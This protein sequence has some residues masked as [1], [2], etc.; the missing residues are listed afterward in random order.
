MVLPIIAIVGRPNVGKSALYNRL[1]GQR[2]AIVSDV[3]GTTRDRVSSDAHWLDS[4][5]ILVD[6]G[7]IEAEDEMNPESVSGLGATQE[8]LGSVQMQTSTALEDADVLIFVVDAIA[9]VTAKDH[10]AADAV[11]RAGKPVVLAAN[12][13]DNDARELTVSEF[14]E[15]GAGD[16]IPISAYHDIGIGELMDAVL[17]LAGSVSEPETDEDTLRIAIV[18]RPN[19]G[20]STLLNAITGESRAIVS[21]VAGT[22]RDAIDTSYTYSGRAITL[23]DTAGLRRRGKAGRGIEKFSVLRAI[24]AIERADVALLLLDA[25]ELITAQDTHVAGLIEDAV[26]GAVIV[27]NKWDLADHDEIDQQSANRDIRIRLK[28][29]E[30]APIT[31]TSAVHGRGVEGMLDAALRVYAEWTRTVDGGDLQRVLLAALAEHPIP[32]HGRGD[33]H[34]TRVVQTRTAPPSF[35]FR[36]NQPD[37]IHFS[38]KRYLENKIR[39]EFGFAGAPLRLHFRTRI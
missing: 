24:Q 15:L 14:Y 30:G 22:T 29:L 39:D 1:L 18:G 20:K 19:V 34:M 28:F 38:Y 3:A 25:T 5:F 9:G 17:K 26:R 32:T 33:V 35:V 2:T 27:V 4:R 21:P 37:R 36:V 23:I 8:L 7:G 31:F 10:D 11:R 13:A 12:K 16:P 6:T